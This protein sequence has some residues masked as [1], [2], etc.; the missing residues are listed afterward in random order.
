MNTTPKTDYEELAK[1]A[2]DLQMFG[3]KLGLS[4]TQALLSRLGDPHLGLKSVHLAGSNGKGST[5]AVMA[6]VLRESG[7]KVGFYSSPHLVSFRER[8][9]INGRMPR[10]DKLAG[11]MARVREVC[12]ESEPPTFFEFTTALA[13]LYF[14]EEKVDAAVIET[15][16]GGRLDATNI[17]RP[18]VSI[19]TT[20]AL[21]HTQYLGHT[22]EEIAFE[23]AGIIK[24]N[25]P[26][27]CGALEP[28]AGEVVAARAA[29]M[30]APL[31]I[32]GRDFQAR[33]QG[34][35]LDYKG[36]SLNLK[37]LKMGLTGPFQA[38]NAALA[39][40]ALELFAGP[41]P[42][43]A[44]EAIRRGLA[45]LTWPG[46]L[47]VIDR[48]PLTILDGAHNP[49]ACRALAGALP[50]ILKDEQ[51]TGLILVMGA[52]SDKDHRPMIEA[53]GP[54]ADRIIFTRPVYERSAEPEVLSRVAAELGLGGRVERNLM[55][56]LDLARGQ[57][58]ES[59]LI[60]V[61]GSLFV[62]G[63]VLEGLGIRPFEEETE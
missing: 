1:W 30:K 59:D 26:L 21:E 32:F 12:D 3:I 60:I 52:M 11:Y 51:K 13:F 36:L 56:A 53:L 22:I 45:G 19:I 33:L 63:E 61:T 62:V 17:I 39:L 40:A 18:K 48:S 28:R 24:E 9:L 16:L 4:S 50:Q 54:L 58:Q 47:Q 41:G 35:E 46:R 25:T 44:E 7:Q 15:G 43:P 8:F 38:P 5:G 23:K 10:P 57:A 29:E 55:E 42:A 2:L 49:E 6:A 20:I 37:G 27:V 34:R 31:Y 14:A